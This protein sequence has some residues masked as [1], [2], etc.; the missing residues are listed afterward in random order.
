MIGNI[1]PRVHISHFIT[2]TRFIYE[3]FHHLIILEVE[4]YNFAQ[5]WLYD[6]FQDLDDSYERDFWSNEKHVGPTVTS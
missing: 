1:S 3:F 5:I 4:P 2:D 6:V